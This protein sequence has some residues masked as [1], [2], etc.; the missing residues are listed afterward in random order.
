ME[1]IEQNPELE[2]DV[3]LTKSSIIEDYFKEYCEEYGIEFS[4]DQADAFIDFL[5]I[6][7]YD[8]INGN[9]KYFFE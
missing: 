2:N 6:D 3:F 7:I 4:E 1:K 9:M 5:E 8:W